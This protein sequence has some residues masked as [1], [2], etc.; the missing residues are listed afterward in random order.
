MGRTTNYGLKQMK[1]NGARI[2]NS[3]PTNRKNATSLLT[4]TK[5]LKSIIVHNMVDVFIFM[6][7]PLPSIFILDLKI[8]EQIFSVILFSSIICSFFLSIILEHE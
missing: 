4:F 2:W 5:S 1:E 6:L 8:Y 7:I 3:L